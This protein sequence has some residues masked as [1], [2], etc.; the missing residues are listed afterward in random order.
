MTLVGMTTSPFAGGLYF[1]TLCVNAVVSS[2][3]VMTSLWPIRTKH[4]SE[5]NAIK[6]DNPFYYT[7]R[8]GTARLHLHWCTALML[9]LCSYM[10]SLPGKGYIYIYI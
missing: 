1:E 5:E 8:S 4:G 6:Q 3:R 9:T 7:C 2:M 10:R